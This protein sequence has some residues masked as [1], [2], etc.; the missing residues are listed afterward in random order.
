MTKIRDCWCEKISTCVF[1][2]GRIVSHGLYPLLLPL[3][4]MLIEW[5]K[6]DVGSC[7]LC[8]LTIE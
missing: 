5:V 3:C 8:S 4:K 7:E 1:S 2:L 6:I